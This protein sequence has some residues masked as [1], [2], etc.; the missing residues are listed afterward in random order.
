MRLDLDTNLLISGIFFGGLPGRILEAWRDGL[1]ELVVSPEIFPE[2]EQ[3]CE[4]L[5]QKHSA[6]PYRRFLSLILSET[7]MV[8]DVSG[9]EA[10]TSD[11]DD[12]KFMLVAREA[13]GV[14]AREGHRAWRF[15][16]PRCGRLGMRPSP[17]GPGTFSRSGAHRLMELSN[18]A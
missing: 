8:R 18:S 7:T 14:I 2:Y 5:A 1:V 11:P 4:R 16:P 17:D 13:D 12:D 15:G 10:I 9:G 6:L 3:V